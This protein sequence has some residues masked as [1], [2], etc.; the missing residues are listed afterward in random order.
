MVILPFG[1]SVLDNSNWDKISHS[2][3][4]QSTFGR[5]WDS[6]WDDKGKK[7]GIVNEIVLFKLWYKGQIYTIP[8]FIKKEIEK[9]NS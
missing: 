4:K 2:L 7:K 9:N 5:E 6:L 3:T 1:D 8:K